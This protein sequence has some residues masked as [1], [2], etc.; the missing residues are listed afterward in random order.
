MVQDSVPGELRDPGDRGIQFVLG[1]LLQWGVLVHEAEGK[2]LVRITSPLQEAASRLQAP[3][4]VRS[5][6]AHYWTWVLFDGYLR[7]ILGYTGDGWHPCSVHLAAV[8]EAAAASIDA[9][10][11]ALGVAVEGMTNALF[12]D[13]API[14]DGFRDLVASLRAHIGDWLRGNEP[15]A[16]AKLPDRISS[17]TGKLLEVRPVDRLKQLAIAGVVEKRHVKAWQELRNAAAHAA[18]PGTREWQELLDRR[19]VVLAMLYRLVFHAI[20]YEGKCADYGTRHWPII[21]FPQRRVTEQA[22]TDGRLTYRL[23][24]Y[25]RVLSWA[26]PPT[27]GTWEW[28]VRRADTDPAEA[29]GTAANREDAAKDCRARTE[30][31]RIHEVVREQTSTLVTATAPT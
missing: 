3:I 7:F 11:L 8:C 12:P 2:R 14:S 22:A 16:E 24:A 17:L 31:L 5:V 19:D 18:Q 23:R 28:S 30:R 26:G 13:L 20:G 29:S 21:E 1:R 27:G 15:A 25:G 10:V 6:A 4:P 9:E